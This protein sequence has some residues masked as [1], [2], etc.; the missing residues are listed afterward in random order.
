M[1][2]QAAGLEQIDE[3]G[4][5]DRCVGRAVETTDQP[6]LLPRQGAA[7]PLAARETVIVN[8]LSAW[9][10]SVEKIRGI[11]ERSDATVVFGHDAQRPRS[12]RVAPNGFH[13]QR[14]PH[15][16]VRPRPIPQEG[17]V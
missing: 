5:V 3:L 16:I 2:R 10:G 13:T 9:Y 12:M 15:L 11:A 8:D 7:E 4:D 6:L 1:K 17:C 14:L